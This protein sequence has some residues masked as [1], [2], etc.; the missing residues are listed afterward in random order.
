[1]GAL[2]LR[3]LVRLRTNGND[4]VLEEDL[5]SDA[6]EGKVYRMTPAPRPVTAPV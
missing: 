1:V 5:L 4:E 3:K 2:K 6:L